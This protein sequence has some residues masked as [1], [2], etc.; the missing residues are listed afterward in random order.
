M[1]AKIGITKTTLSRWTLPFNFR[2]H[3]S[4][5]TRQMLNVGGGNAIL[6]S[7]G[8]PARIKTQR[9][10]SVQINI[11]RIQEHFKVFTPL[12]NATVK[13]RDRLPKS[14]SLTFKSL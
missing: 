13:F 2:A 4:A 8:T 9:D 7:E 11:M 5:Q 14:N 12:V 6:R 10:N 3:I 1:S